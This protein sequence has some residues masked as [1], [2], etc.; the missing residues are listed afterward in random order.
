MEI[1]TRKAVGHFLI[2]AKGRLD[3]SWADFFLDSVLRLI[4]E[5]EH[6]LLVEASGLEFISSAGIR[7]L[8]MINKELA[9]VGGSFYLLNT[10]DFISNTLKTT[11]F[12]AWLSD[13]RVYED[14]LAQSK[15]DRNTEKVEN[16][17][18][19][20]ENGGLTFKALDVWKP[21]QDIAKDDIK[22][23]SFDANS[24]ALG[25][26]CPASGENLSQLK[27]GEYL[28]VGGHIIY[29]APEEKARPDFLIPTGDY[30]PQMQC[31]QTI[32]CQGRM[33]RL[34]RFSPEEEG[35]G[36]DISGLAE[37]ALDQNNTNMAAFVIL[38]EID[39]MLGASL[40]S[41]P[42]PPPVSANARYTELR[43]AL[44]FT[45]DRAYSGEQGLVFGL[46]ARN[47]KKN[48]PLLKTLPSRP[49]LAAHIHAA[50]FPY[51]ALQNGHIDLDQQL[52]RFFNGP[53][54]LSLLHLIDDKRPGIGLGETGFI[55]GALWSA[56]IKKKE[57]II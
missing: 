28:A 39:G 55:R 16:F 12:G 51:Q 30:V 20:D 44:S 4:R 13:E 19:L 43:E 42:V 46:V 53:P 18:L 38:A 40:I 7:S 35:L 6:H 33:A 49:E 8:L 25:I 36:F 29:Q 9:S 48:H 3:A 14:S 22:T 2:I 45:D 21:W 17:F 31:I 10:K 57:D 37:K 56:P 50:V 54:P 15:S 32:L 47:D 41:N 24:F 34:W 1:Q 52:V 11:G 26:A 23:L 5:G 27:F